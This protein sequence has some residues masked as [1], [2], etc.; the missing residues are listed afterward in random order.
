MTAILSTC[1]LTAQNP[2]FETSSIALSHASGEAYSGRLEAK[3]GLPLTLTLQ[4]VTLQFC[5][6]QAYSAKEYEVAGPGW[7]KNTKYNITATLPAGTSIDRVWP[8]LQT[9]LAERLQ[10]TVRREERELTIYDMT[11]AKDG[12]KLVAAP[13]GG[14]GLKFQPAGM[15]GRSMGN[16]S[17]R[18]SRASVEEFCANLSSKVD[19]PVVDR[20]GLTGTFKFEFRFKGESRAAVSR[21]LEKQLGLTLAPA[22]R[23][24]SVLVV[25]N[26]LREPL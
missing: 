22:T 10:L 19:R 21:E 18:L 24:V 16:N 14:P 3:P 26:A 15:K 12:P 23:T 20:T 9:L 7:I 8:A 2:N 17:V 13:G 6:Q 11:V 5:I 25:E 4:N 1:V